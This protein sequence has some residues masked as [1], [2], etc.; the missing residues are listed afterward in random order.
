M[1][2]AALEFATLLDSQIPIR[3]YSWLVLG[4]K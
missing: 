1:L 2:L 3:P 4:Y